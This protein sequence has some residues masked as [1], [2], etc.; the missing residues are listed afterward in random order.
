ML[1]IEQDARTTRQGDSSHTEI[2]SAGFPDR[3]GGQ[4][5]AFSPRVQQA[6]EC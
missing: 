6:S 3:S 4:L 5:T 2:S 1:C